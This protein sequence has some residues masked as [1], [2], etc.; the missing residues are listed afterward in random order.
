MLMQRMDV[1]LQVKEETFRLL[2]ASD[3]ASFYYLLHEIVHATR[4][5]QEI[6]RRF[7]L[8]E[9]LERRINSF[10][11]GIAETVGVAPY[12]GAGYGYS[13]D[14]AITYVVPS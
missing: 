12:P 2:A 9:D 6:S 5:G 14:T 10:A 11:R 8:G 7:G 13:T 3:E 1:A 4:F